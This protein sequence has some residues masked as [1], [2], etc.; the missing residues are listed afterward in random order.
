MGMARGF[1]VGIE[2]CGC[3]PGEAHNLGI[4]DD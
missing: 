2:G 3:L 4:G 1:S